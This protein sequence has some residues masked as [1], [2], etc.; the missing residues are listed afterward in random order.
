MYSTYSMW[1]CIAG[2]IGVREHIKHTI[3]DHTLEIANYLPNS[4]LTKVY[5]VIFQ[6]HCVYQWVIITF[7]AYKHRIVS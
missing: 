7:I 2:N 1:Y 4:P 6:H 5:N 3:H